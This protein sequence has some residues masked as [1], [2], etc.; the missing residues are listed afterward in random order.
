MEQKLSEQKQPSPEKKREPTEVEKALDALSDVRG[1]EL[2]GSS[3]GEMSEFGAAA[4]EFGE[5][6]PEFGDLGGAEEGGGM[7]G[8]A[9]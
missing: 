8:D 9:N 7:G 2:G 5:S 1:F 4:P 3:D 6:A